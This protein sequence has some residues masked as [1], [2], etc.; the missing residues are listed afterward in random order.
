VNQAPFIYDK[1]MHDARK[2]WRER[3]DA[4]SFEGYVALDHPRPEGGQPQPAAFEVALEPSA[5]ALLRRLTAGNPFLSYTVLVLALQ[6]GCSRYS[7]AKSVTTFSPATRGEP[8]NLLP[9]SGLLAEHASFK[10][11]LLATKELL[12]GAYKNQSYPFARMALDLPEGRRPQRPFLIASL[13]GFTGEPPEG[14]YDIAVTF[15]VTEGGTKALVRF[16]GR[17]YETSTL[18]HFFELFGAILQQGLSQMG[19]RI[20]DLGRDRGDLTPATAVDGA[21]AEEATIEPLHRRFEAQV[22]KRP[23]GVAL[24]HGDRVVTYE[25]LDR[26]ATRLAEALTEL[27]LGRRRPI[28]LL[29][30]AGTELI[31]G[32]LAA[33]KIG[34]AFA[35]VE[36]PSIQRPLSQVLAALNAECVLCLR[37]QVEDLRQPDGALAGVEHVVSVEWAAS[38]DDEGVSTL[39]IERHS[40]A[41]PP[42]EGEG[43]RPSAAPEQGGGWAGGAQGAACVLIDGGE[44][45]PS[46]SVVTHAKIAR[47]FE[48]LNERGDVGVHDRCLLPPGLGA[49]EQLYDTLGML[50]AGAGV[51]IADAAS[52]ADPTRFA[53]RL[54]AP[55]ITVWALPTPLA[56]NLLASLVALRAAR[57]GLRGP[58]VILL[59]GEKQGAGLANRL[60]KS[61][62]SAQ[63]TGLYA[64]A[65]VGLWSTVFSFGPEQA[66]PDR[67]V[68]GRAIGGVEHRV[69]GND[70]RPVPPHTKGEL[71]LLRPPPGP[72]GPPTP[73]WVN[74]GL[75]AEPLGDGGLRWLRGDD[76]GF[77]KYG[78]RVELTEVEAALC[79]H[80]HIWAAEVMVVKSGHPAD[81]SVV[82]FVVVEPGR[83][84]AESA[85][86]FL[87][88]RGG[89][90]LIPDRFVLVPEF[91]LAAGGAID[92]AALRRLFA[93]SHEP[94]DAARRIEAGEIHRRLK[95]V[96]LEVLQLDEV[97]D[98]DSFFSVGGNSLKATLLLARI[99][100]DFAVDLSVQKF[101]REPNLRAVAQ[102]IADEARGPARP[103]SGPA[104]KVVPRERYR[105]QLPD[106]ER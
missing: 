28:A 23:G 97:G 71:H 51:E 96:W 30:G 94:R 55:E 87:V 33:L 74:T 68:V 12:A 54:L 24:V 59:S 98:D 14:P 27:P 29:L 66:R 21:G 103:P 52:L 53:E 70:G 89:V 86:D 10:E 85:R 7:G 60:A 36:L 32:M 57:E 45:D 75:R 19:T 42:A 11:A 20:A 99:R 5:H 77:V 41:H 25:A 80:E 95:G 56:Q 3:L 61:F 88:L 93:A 72:G 102:Q 64:N 8:A 38:T 105:V 17:L 13:A 18:R 79:E 63:I 44:G 9:V 26:H 58:R 92:R 84:S 49:C 46:P 2:Y 73:S 83:V 82:A 39:A 90:D 100:D 78:C 101:F 22:A 91:P 76:H 35:P 34:A 37:G 81:G 50:I 62:S 31:V 69:V 6:V 16:D 67:A 40:R 65:A 48:W 4:M 1:A 43:D 106:A 47:L 15:E 104:L